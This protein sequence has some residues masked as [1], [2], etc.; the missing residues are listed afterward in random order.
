MNFHKLYTLLE[1]KSEDLLNKNPEL[2]DAYKNGI[3]NI[4]QL[5][6][7]LKVKGNEPVR[8]I[9]PVL[10]AFERNKQRLT[11]K[12]IL[13]YRT[14]GELRDALEEVGKSKEQRGLE[15]NSSETTFLGKFGPW[16]IVMP[17]TKESSCYWG[18]GTTWCTSYT[19]SG[20]MFFHY[21]AFERITLFYLIKEG[22]NPRTE[23]ESKLSIGFANGEIQH[24]NNS[25]VDAANN[26]LGEDDLKR[27]LG[28]EYKSIMRSIKSHVGVLDDKHPAREVMK[29]IASGESSVNELENELA[30]GDSFNQYDNKMLIRGIAQYD[31]T[32]DG[33][34]EIL[35]HF[36]VFG[37]DEESVQD[38]MTYSKDLFKTALLLIDYF[39]FER[40]R[41][42]GKFVSAI[43]RFGSINSMQELGLSF[44]FNK[45][46]ELMRIL[47]AKNLYLLSY[48]EV[49]ELFAVVTQKI[50]I[51]DLKKGEDPESKLRG[52]FAKHAPEWDNEKINYALSKSYR[53]LMVPSLNTPSFQ[54]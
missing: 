52:L 10:L 41:I 47:G 31:L 39:K 35:R 9:V 14:V 19:Q 38:L 53:D 3:K 16:Y 36:L 4:N 27:I 26:N 46:D 45:L 51:E 33:V 12:D 28:V 11:N 22:G 15:Q 23:P 2:V 24:T 40:N 21:S 13:A 34:Y 25:T 50:G 6:W 30:L 1:G 20:N 42:K 17:H 18:K 8:D 44:S 37:G 54:N 48:A 43:L 5:S 29:R 7:I 49:K 32:I